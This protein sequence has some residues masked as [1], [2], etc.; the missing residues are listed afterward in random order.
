MASRVVNRFTVEAKLGAVA[1]WSYSNN[2]YKAFLD[3]TRLV[4]LKRVGGTS[5]ELAT[6]PCVAVARQA[7][8]VQLQAIGLTLFAKAW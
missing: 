2:R 3:G 5:V 4:L 7:Y 8:S 1:R 6:V